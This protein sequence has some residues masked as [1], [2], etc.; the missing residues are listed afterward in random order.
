M[1]ALEAEAVH[2]DFDLVFGFE[3]VGGRIVF[4]HVAHQSATTGGHAGE[5][6]LGAF[7]VIVGA[8]P[9]LTIAK[10][11]GTADSIGMVRGNGMP[12]GVRENSAVAGLANK[13]N[14]T[15]RIP[16]S[17][18]VRGIFEEFSAMATGHQHEV[19]AIFLGDFGEEELNLEV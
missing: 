11:D 4:S 6:L 9:H 3:I 13:L 5:H 17:G 1:R 10:S 19:G 14:S 2:D 16:F 12:E 8:A 7:F 18:S 15:R